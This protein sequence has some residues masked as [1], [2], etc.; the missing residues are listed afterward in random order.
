MSRDKRQGSGKAAFFKPTKRKA[1]VF[2]II[3]CFSYFYVPA[4]RCMED[5]DVS[6]KVCSAYNHSEEYC[7]TDLYFSLSTIGLSYNPEDQG[8]FCPAKSI[9][10]LSMISLTIIFLAA[11]YIITCILDYY[12]AK[13][14]DK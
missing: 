4:I 11:A 9:S 14:R 5:Q 2:L 6:K 3:F 13:F 7:K 12:Y 10:M 8:F 1:L